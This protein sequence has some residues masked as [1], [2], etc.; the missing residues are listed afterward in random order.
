[1]FCKDWKITKE[2]KMPRH[3]MFMIYN[4]WRRE[5]ATY[6]VGERILLVVM[7]TVLCEER[8]FYDLKGGL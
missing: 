5:D 7:N 8:G 2:G 6:Y 4:I 3:N 1:V